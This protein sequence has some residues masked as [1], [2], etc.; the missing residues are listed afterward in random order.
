MELFTLNRDY[1]RM[2]TVD[3]FSSAIWT[4]RVLGDDDFQVNVP[5]TPAIMRALSVGT[6]VGLVGSKVLMRID[7]QTIKDNVLKVVG[8]SLMQNL[9]I[10]FIRFTAQHLDKSYTIIGS[11]G[12]VLQYLVQQMAIDGP[13]L[14]GTSSMGIP[15]PSRLKIPFFS[16]QDYDNQ[17]PSVSIQVPYGPLY[18]ALKQIAKAYNLTQ[19]IEWN[20][21]NN[22][23]Y[24]NWLGVDHTSEGPNALVRF[25]TQLDN[26]AST[27]EIVDA[28]NFKTNAFSFASALGTGATFLASEDSIQGSYNGWDLRAEMVFND[29]IKDAPVDQPDLLPNVLAQRAYDSLVS[30]QIVEAV[31]GQVLPTSQYVYGTHYNLGDVIEAQGTSGIIQNSRVT[32]FIR[33]QDG[34]GEKAY[35][36]LVA[37]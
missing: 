6:F 21:E 5:A 13:W 1:A 32:E 37:I 4:E 12:Y 26:F 19:R 27:T 22:I 8:R 34:S 28:T 9:N 33:A 20:G 25:S 10:R 29:D 24:R 2:S 7:S 31:D 18:D 3:Y 16:V 15:N 11:P 35:P 23:V 17:L 30:S 14:S 36:T